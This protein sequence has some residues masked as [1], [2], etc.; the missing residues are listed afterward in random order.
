MCQEK[1]GKKKFFNSQEKVR[2]FRNFVKSQE[3]FNQS[4][5]SA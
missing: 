2:K 4:A 3:K 5:K 1:V